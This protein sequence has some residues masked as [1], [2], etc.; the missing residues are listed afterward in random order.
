MNVAVTRARKFV[1]LIGDSLTV[2]SDE[3]LGKLVKYFE[4]F[5]EVRNALE[6]KGN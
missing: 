1:C 5:G 2:S 3:F 6:F 4:D